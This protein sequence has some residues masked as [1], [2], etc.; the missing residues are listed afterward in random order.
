MTDTPDLI[1]PVTAYRAWKVSTGWRRPVQQQ[2]KGFVG[3]QSM[4]LAFVW[5]RGP[6]S[7][8]CRGINH[9]WEQKHQPHEA[10]HPD[11]KCGIYVM[12]TLDDLLTEPTQIQAIQR[13]PSAR[14]LDAPP[15]VAGQVEVW[16]RTERYER[17][18]RV[19]WA[20]VSALYRTPLAGECDVEELAERYGVPV[21]DAPRIE[22]WKAEPQETYEHFP[23]RW[24]TSTG[25]RS[26]HAG[27]HHVHVHHT[28]DITPYVNAMGAAVKTL[29]DVSQ[30]M[31]AY[32]DE[33]TVAHDSDA[34]HHP[35][36][37]IPLRRTD[38]R[39]LDRRRTR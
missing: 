20:K 38:Y 28:V 5:G 9:L 21:L 39:N 27:A 26:Y 13:R 10:P 7:A 4:A 6:Q 11:C 17:G 3:L 30:V 8:D 36:K 14:A 16:G 15:I 33:A 25:N 37:P 22:A 24:I 19:E 31:R 2:P 32:V 34:D 18:R 12:H 29:A 1:G 35:D 23:Q